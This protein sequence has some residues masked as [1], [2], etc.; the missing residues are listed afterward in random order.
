MLNVSTIARRCNFL[1]CT[2]LLSAAVASA[3]PAV[4]RHYLRPGLPDPALLLAPPPLPGSSEQAAD[5]ASVVS[6]HREFGTNSSSVAM[7]E[8]KYSVF[9]FTGVIGGWFEPVKLPKSEAFFERVQGD[10]AIVLERAKAFWQRPRPYTVEP[11]LAAG[12]LEKSFSY[13]SGHSTQA[14]VLALVLAEVFPAQRDA[15]LDT[16][17]ALGWHRVQLGRHYPTDIY[18]GR[19]LAQAL[20]Q[21][22]RS[23][24]DFQR[25][26]AEIK[27][28]IAAA[29]P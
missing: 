25:D 26:L 20:V 3:A 6:V 17:Y 23:N 7:S 24:Q 5:L 29:R 11:S 14:A 15:I 22:M 16:G 18:A 9:N 28:E 8:K 12:K 1:L 2:L 27:N 4:T 19:V 13:P 21:E 10:A